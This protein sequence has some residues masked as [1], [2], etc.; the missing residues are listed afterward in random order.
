MTKLQQ[1]K[2]DAEQLERLAN[3]A[4]RALKR[5]QAKDAEARELAERAK[6]AEKAG[7]ATFR[8][9]VYKDEALEQMTDGSAPYIVYRRRSVVP[10]FIFR[11][12]GAL[13]CSCAFKKAALCV[14]EE[15]NKLAAVAVA[16]G[17]GVA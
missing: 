11:E 15:L 7:I 9:I 4:Q 3:E 8:P 5:E 2:R 12:D 13:I 17:K 6:R 14:V 1:L 10:Y 16:V